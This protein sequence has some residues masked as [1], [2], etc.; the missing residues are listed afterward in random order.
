ME[1]PG[2]RRIY[3]IE[4]R[5]PT[6]PA[7]QLIYNPLIL[8]PEHSYQATKGHCIMS[9]WVL[10]SGKQKGVKKKKGKEKKKKIICS[11]PRSSQDSQIF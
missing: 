9:L 10:K 1:T 5:Q 2:V 8:L 7:D 3:D 11:G 4:I 6:R